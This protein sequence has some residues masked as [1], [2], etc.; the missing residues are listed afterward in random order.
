VI[1]SP[2]GG[3]SWTTIAE[4]GMNGIPD[5]ASLQQIIYAPANASHP[6]PELFIGGYGGVWSAVMDDNPEPLT[7]QSVQW[8][9][10]KTRDNFNMWNTNLEY[11][12][13]DDVIVASI[14]GQGTWL[15]NRSGQ[16]LVPSQELAP[17]MRISELILPQDIANYKT[18]KGRNNQ[19]SINITLTRDNSNQGKDV[20]V[21]LE[22]GS[23]W[24][25]YL[26]IARNN[27]PLFNDINDNK[28]K[29]HLPKGVDQLNF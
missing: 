19:G 14:M 18:R 12:P 9:G 3:K 10:S 25:D 27:Q 24:A 16:T 28:L 8:S 17:G 1:Y 26:E 11:D 22:L 4:S 29:L 5:S 21:D 7:F 23:D 2:D 15:L 13:Q 20:S 6:S